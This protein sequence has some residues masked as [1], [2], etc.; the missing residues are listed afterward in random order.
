MARHRP[1]GR[2]EAVSRTFPTKAAARNWAARVE[3]EVAEGRYRR[4]A[5]GRLGDV[6]DAYLG[7]VGELR[8]LGRTKRAA[9]EGL[10]ER[11]GHLPLRAPD[12][13]TLVRFAVDRKREGAGPV[14]I[15]VDLSYLGTILI[16]TAP[17]FAT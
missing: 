9:I 14:T 16:H 2:G 4:P 5:R 6:I 13:Q 11:L 8:G 7:E 15:G 17:G 3:H 1:Q 10:R 12:T